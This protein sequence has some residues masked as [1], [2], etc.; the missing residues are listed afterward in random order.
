MSE[1]TLVSALLLDE[2][3]VQEKYINMYIER[4]IH[5]LKTNLKKIIIVDERIIDRLKPY[6]N[7]NTTIVVF[8]RKN[9]YL[10]SMESDITDK[11]YY[12]D[13]PRDV[14]GYY[15][16]TCNKTEF[17]RTAIEIDPNPS[18]Y[19]LWI[20]FGIKH[21][22]KKSDEDFKKNVESL[23]YKLYDKVRIGHI[24]DLNT[25][26]SNNVYKS[27]LWY[28]AGGVFGGS[29]EYI[30]MFADKVKEK[31]ID[32]IK[33]KHTLMWEVNVWYLV[34]KENQELFNPY[35]CVHDDTIIDNF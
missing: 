13:N 12:S 3:T 20:D 5:L 18:K 7:E 34:Y 23:Q 30:L 14:V 17:I 11:T 24:W 33:N 4:G 8:D 28:F 32:L 1:V 10:Y 19:Y 16:I 21:V 6:E 35:Y 27:V 25:V 26:Y 15:L 22:Y 31:C 29:R 2:R 9:N